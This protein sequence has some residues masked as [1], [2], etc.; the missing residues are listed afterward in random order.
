MKDTDENLRKEA[1]AT[2]LQKVSKNFLEKSAAFADSGFAPRIA[3]KD[4]DSRGR[5]RVNEK[6]ER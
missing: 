6:R 1:D 3:E 5:Q 4:A 2:L